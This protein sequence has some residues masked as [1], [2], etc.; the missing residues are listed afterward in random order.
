[1]SF[2]FYVFSHL[3]VKN[4]SY[5]VIFGD[6]SSFND[7]TEAYVFTTVFI[8]YPMHSYDFS[9]ISRDIKFH[10]RTNIGWINEILGPQH[11]P[12]CKPW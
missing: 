9:R 8:S 7:V 5:V 12:K 6:E 2:L 1:M 10:K 11:F 4:D 3:V